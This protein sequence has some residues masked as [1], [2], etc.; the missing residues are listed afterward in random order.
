MTSITYSQDVLVV[1]GSTS[2][3]DLTRATDI[4]TRLQNLNVF[5]SVTGV[6]LNSAN[7]LSLSDLNQYDA[8]MIA[9]NGGY[10]ASWG[11]DAVLRDY[12]DAGGGVAV[13]MF[14]NASIP[15]GSNWPYN[16]LLPASQS[17]GTTSIG[18]VQLPGH[19]TLNFPYIINTDTWTIG[20]TFSSRVIDLA[21]WPGYDVSHYTNGDQMLVNVLTWLMGAIQVTQTGNCINANQSDFVF[22]DNNDSNPVVSYA[23]D[24]GDS[25][26][27]TLIN[28]LKVYTTSG[29]FPVTVTV[30]RQNSQQQ[31]Y[32]T[33]VTIFDLPS[34]ADAGT[35]VTLT[36]GT[37]STSLTPTTP[38]I[39]TGTWSFVSG[40]NTPT[41]T[42]SNTVANL[43][44]LID[45]DYAFSWTIANGTCTVST[46]NITVNI[47]STDLDPTVSTIDDIISCQDT[48]SDSITF[49]VGDDITATANLVIAAT[50]NNQSLLPDANIIL[51]GSDANRTIVVT[52][53][54]GQSGTSTVTVSVTDESANVTTITFDV[55]FGDTTNPI[56][57]AQDITIQLDANGVATISSTDN[58]GI[59][60]MVLDITDFT[61]NDLGDTTVTLTVT[62]NLGNSNTATATV[63]VEDNIAPNV[64]TQNITVQLDANGAASIV[65]ADIDNGSTDNCEIASLELDQTVFGCE[66][67]SQF[68][69]RI[70]ALDTDGD[71]YEYLMDA[72]N[73]LELV[74]TANISDGNTTFGLAFAPVTQT[75]YLLQNNNGSR[76]LFLLDVNTRQ[77]TFL[78]SMVSLGGNT[79]PQTIASDGGSGIYVVYSSGEVEQF[80]PTTGVATNVAT[81]ENNGA[82]GLTYDFDANR[83]LYATNDSPAEIYEVLTDGS[84][85]VNLLFSTTF[86]GD[87]GQAIEYIGNN[88]A[89]VSH[90]SNARGYIL[91]VNTGTFETITQ[92]PGVLDTGAP[93]GEEVKSF[94]YTTL[95]DATTVTLTVTDTS[96][97]SAQATAMVIVED[98][99]TT[100][101]IECTETITVNN[102]PGTSGAVVTIVTPT[103]NS[104][105]C[106]VNLFVDGPRVD[107]NASENFELTDTPYVLQG[108]TETTLNSVELKVML[109]GD[110]GNDTECFVLEG[111]D[112]SV[113]VDQC[114][115]GSDGVIGLLTVNVEAATWNTWVQTY[116]ADLTFTL[117]EDDNVETDDSADG[118][119]F[120][121]FLNNGSASTISNNYTNS[122]DASAFYPIGTTAV[123]WEFVAANG[124]TETCTFD[125]IVIDN[126][127][128]VGVCPDDIVVTTADDGCDA[129]VTF[130][131]PTV[132]DNSIDNVQS[133]LN[134]VGGIA[135]NMSTLIPDA[136]DF[137]LDEGEN[138][139]FI[140]DGRD[141]MYDDGNFLSTNFSSLFNYSENTIVS[142]G[143]FGTNGRYATKKETNLWMLAA[144][145]DGVTSFS[146]TGETGADGDGIVNAYASTITVE[147]LVYSIFVKRTIEE[148]GDSSS[149]PSINH[150]IIIPE[151][152]NATQTISSDTD[153]D[154][155][156]IS[157]LAGTNELYYFLFATDNGFEVSNS[158]FETIATNFITALVGEGINDITITQTEGLAS[159]STFPQGTTTNT[160]EF[161]DAAGNASTC[162]FDV[163]V[164]DNVDPIPVAQNITVALGV[165]G[166]VSITPDMVDNGSSDNCDF[167][168]VVIPSTFGCDNLGPNAVILIVSDTAGNQ[169]F[170]TAIVTVEDTTAATIVT[171]DITV[172]L[173]ANGMAS[174][175]VSDIDNGST[176][177]C[178]IDTMVLDITD[179]SCDDLGENTVTLTVTDNEGNIDTATAVVTVVDD[180][181][182]VV[183]ECPED[184][185][186]DANGS[187]VYVMEN[188]YDVLDITDN[189]STGI[190][191][192]QD[193]VV[194]TELTVGIT[195]V[196]I[197]VTDASGNST[198]CMFN[199]TTTLGTGASVALPEL[200]LYPNPASDYVMIGKPG[201]ID[202]NKVTVFDLT[203]RRVEMYNYTNTLHQ[204]EVKVDL[205]RLPIA[206]YM[207]HIQAA[208][209][210]T[211]YKMVIKK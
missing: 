185:A 61:C 180:I 103:I 28:P 38:A 117:K 106:A 46:D 211:A 144:E 98:N 65:T 201:G 204:T 105:G 93:L 56:A 9:T 89:F 165:N 11:F 58:C 115:I 79:Q 202:I 135:A 197:A 152:A 112:A 33:S 1:F 193:P 17:S 37:T 203:G 15:L 35:D 70:F 87:G 86:E 161:T 102:D 67:I 113:I 145:M 45:G 120:K 25:T 104:T 206:S 177:N 48:S 49:T 154:T 155:N 6:H 163:I 172:Q 158:T 149:D 18:D 64:I 94:M 7:Q 139:N 209:G 44:G 92:K 136:S 74:Q 121:L 19:P 24:F 34:T 23:W 159:G 208:N 12:V 187:D 77:S 21:I 171:Q 90:N 62:D 82:V 14:A 69:N 96:G 186:V 198:N 125:V 160:F 196:T 162:S 42:Q 111:P 47:G 143:V 22:I 60:T 179:F 108:V 150:L 52:P 175:E 83:L 129:V 59:D 132:T 107:F 205:S 4:S 146:I 85:T 5:N 3:A 168:M 26:T 101:T 114:N 167:T 57:V 137:E 173:D 50:S 210:L 53:I 199:I 8:V 72:T 147:G 142:N 174:I 110:F 157:G 169:E 141:D 182:P 109:Q 170:T 31:T 119:W 189:C 41:L 73:R 81:V 200:K 100:Y 43:S 153:D 148:I 176:D 76:S 51:G 188:Y 195:P 71:F 16:A 32:G 80:N 178:G 29:N 151:N 126:E 20:S 131:L 39:G 164:E 124:Q 166:Q 116:G 122:V 192:T 181:A 78:Q 27:S 95:T 190:I 156:I 123:T 184:V 128:P 75:T 63:T 133:A 118:N 88:K 30:T 130:D 97:N 66:D 191:V 13:M 134:V 194:G 127:A 207:L 55:T 54:S 36:S 183:A 2:S 138:A 91:D 68:G 140:N 99:I 84:G 40:P 10:N